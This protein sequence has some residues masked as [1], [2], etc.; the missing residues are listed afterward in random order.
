MEPSSCSACIDDL[1]DQ[2]A[3]LEFA[4]MVHSDSSKRLP[5][6]HLLQYPPLIFN[7]SSDFSSND[8]M[9]YAVLSNHIIALPPPSIQYVAVATLLPS[10]RGHTVRAPYHAT[11][12]TCFSTTVYQNMYHGTAT[13]TKC[14]VQNPRYVPCKTLSIRQML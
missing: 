1:Y 6:V 3:S 10:I 12:Q 7:E 8:N 13:C 2:L 11:Q 5:L 9:L 4:S 14:T